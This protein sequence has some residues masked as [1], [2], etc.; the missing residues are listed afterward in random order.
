MMKEFWDERYINNE[1][2]YGFK[3]NRFLEDQLVELPLGEILLPA[4]GEGRN[5]IF[6]AKLG[7]QVHAF[8]FSEVAQQK[9][10][11]FAK[12]N[13]VE[14]NYEVIDLT[15]FNA[16]E[17]S[18]DVIALIYV[19]LKPDLRT[20]FHQ[21]IARWLK[22]GGKLILE[23]FNLKQLNNHS[24]GPKD[25]DMLYSRSMLKSDF[26]QTFKIDYC[27]DVTLWLEEGPFHEGKADV[28]R[29]IATKM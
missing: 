28:V 7:W 23:A 8:D 24:G 22:P 21:K 5:A 26:N 13:Q 6:A 2:V 20:S 1:M 15:Q 19:H 10:L 25:E 29:L 9:A 17:K 14:V 18:F 11:A 12:L 4:E 27:G 3:P 16:P